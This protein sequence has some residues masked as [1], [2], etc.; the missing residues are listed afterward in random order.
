MAKIT[1]E[2]DAPD[3]LEVEEIAAYVKDACEVLSK[4]K[5]EE[6]ATK[7]IVN[8]EITVSEVDNKG[9][10]TEIEFE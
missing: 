8:P 9:I 1:L 7:D 3:N 5:A 4:N 6:E 2:F 10:K